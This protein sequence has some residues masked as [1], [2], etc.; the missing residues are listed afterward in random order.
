MAQRTLVEKLERRLDRLPKRPEYEPERTALRTALDYA[1]KGRDVDP[2]KGG[3]S[4]ARKFYERADRLR[5]DRIFGAE[6][7]KDAVAHNDKQA[8]R[9]D[10]ESSGDGRDF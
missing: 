4:D 10:H 5:A 2:P 3:R 1:R 6:A 8:A 7:A 9:G